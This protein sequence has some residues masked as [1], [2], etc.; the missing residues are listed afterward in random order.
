MGI[1]NRLFGRQRNPSETLGEAIERLQVGIVSRLSLNYRDHGQGDAV[2]LANCV[3]SYAITMDPVGD[4]AKS[5][6]REHQQLIHDEARRLAE[7]EGVPEALSYLYAA[8]TL[9]LAILQGDPLSAQ[10]VQL[11]DRADE[12]SLIIPSSYDICGSGDAVHCIKSI[13]VFADDYLR[14]AFVTYH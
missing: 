8:I 3:L 9:R 13:A 4:E 1:L 10:A 7:A 14:G 12:L 6:A 2:H 11:S 5:F